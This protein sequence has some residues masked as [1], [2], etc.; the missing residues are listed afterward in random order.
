MRM[1]SGFG[2]RNPEG[3]PD[4]TAYS[5]INNVEKTPVENKTSSEDEE[6][7]HKLLNTIFTICELS[8]GEESILDELSTEYGMPKAEILRRGLRMQHNLLRHTG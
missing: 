4:P 8:D 1:I 3:Y 2:Y 7:F 5:A 6:R